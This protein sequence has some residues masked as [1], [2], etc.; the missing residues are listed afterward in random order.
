MLN[1]RLLDILFIVPHYKTKNGVIWN[2]I[3]YRF[4]SPGILSLTTY[5]NSNNFKATIFDCNL[6]QIEEQKFPEVFNK[7]FGNSSFR[8]IGI[9]CT[10]QT[11][12]QA[13]R[14]AAWL[15][16]EQPETK[17][18][19]G[20]AHPTSL[21]EFVLKN[22]SVDV[23][24]V[25][26]GEDPVLEL[27]KGIEFNNINGI[28]YKTDGNIKIN[29]PHERIKNL[30]D[31]PLNDYSLIPIHLSK[32]LVGTYRKLPATI[33]VTSR[34]C[35]CSCTFCSRVLG[36]ELH[37]MSPERVIEEIKI[38]YFHY[39]IRQIIFYDDTFIS[40]KARIEEFC[41]LLIQSGIKISWTCSSRV[42]RVYP[43][44]LAKMKKAGCHQIMFG[45]ES[46]DET[47]LQNINKRVTKNDI[48]YA[49]TETKKAGIEARAAIMI[50]N[51]GDT[52][53]ILENNIKELIRLNPDI[54]QVTL[55]TPLPGSRMFADA[56]KKNRIITYDW[57]K[58]DGKDCLLSHATLS[59][60]T[61]LKYYKKT[62]LRFYLRPQF[63]LKQLFNI[64]SVLRTKVLFTGLISLLP[65]VFTKTA[66]G[67]ERS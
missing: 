26:E 18:I 30:N 13:L 24:V 59:F 48:I 15:K 1:R 65:L 14:I 10:T 35:P 28:A 2:A 9:S 53:T 22:N 47:V 62:Y 45:V 8:F 21:P 29:P 34:G 5:I 63:I 67:E 38:L 44:T 41:T 17:I 46:F 57:D 11:I 42:D 23:V 64:Q 39:N 49:I 40:N 52:E 25:G 56:M 7:R 33:M 27:L 12:N 54:I 51:P 50:G 20:G 3:D 6:E 32:P 60:E 36:H 66:S 37:Y 4:H 61:M 43:D 19:F 16:K 31:L 58:Y 55:T